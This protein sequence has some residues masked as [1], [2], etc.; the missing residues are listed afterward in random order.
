VFNPVRRPK[1]ATI[2]KLAELTVARIRVH[3]AAVINLWLIRVRS[4]AFEQ[5]FASTGLRKNPCPLK[6]RV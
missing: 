1:A 2:Y 5:R 3:L 6:K 4:F